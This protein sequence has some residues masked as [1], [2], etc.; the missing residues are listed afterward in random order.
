MADFVARPVQVE[1]TLHTE[2]AGGPEIQQG[3][4]RTVAAIKAIAERR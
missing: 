1:V 3:L 2:R 4:Q